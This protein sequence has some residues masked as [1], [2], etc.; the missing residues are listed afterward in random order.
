MKTDIDRL[1]GTSL[2]GRYRI[3][4]EIG[5]GGMGIVYRAHDQRL[6]RFVA[7]KMIRRDANDAT[8]RTRLWREAR[9]AATLSHPHLCRLY[10]IHE[11]AGELFLT[12]ELLDGESL[13]ARLKRGQIALAE[14]IEIGL[15]ILSALSEMHQRHLAHRDL[16]P[17]NVFLTSNGV[18]LL[19]FGLTRRIPTELTATETNLTMAGA[20]VGTPAYMAPEQVFGQP[21]DGRSDLFAL[22][23]VLFEML[24]AT[25][26]FR[27]DS[28][29]DVLHAITSEQPPMLTGS[30]CVVAVGRIVHRALA[31]NP[32]DRP[33]TAAEMADALRATL[34]VGDEH[35]TVTVRAI[36][37]IMV[38]PFRQLRPD[39]EL[40]FLPFGLAD[41]ITTA[42]AGL[43]SVIV[44]STLTAA[45]FATHE[46]SWQTIAADANVDVVLAGTLLRV[47]NELRVTAQL[48]ETPSGRVVWS[49]T[50][51]VS[52]H[53]LFRLQDDLA[54]AMIDAL[55]LPLTARE[56]RLLNH[57]APTSA[58]AYELYLRANP[59]AE[60]G[61]WTV[62]R[63]LYVE[64]LQ[65]DH[66]FAPGWARLG[67]VYRLLGKFGGHEGEL[68]QRRAEEAFGRAL[69]INP[70]L[71][72][73]HNQ[74]ARLEIDLGRA[75]DA[76]ARLLGRLRVRR[77]DPE[78]FA[79]L[80]QAC[81][82]CGLL[83]ASVAA[84]EA[85]R[86]LDPRM[87]T[88]VAHSYVML[89]RYHDALH[90]SGDPLTRALVLMMLGRKD[91]SIAVLR[92]VERMDAVTIR[93]WA[94]ASRLLVEGHRDEGLR[95]ARTVLPP[96]YKDPESRYYLAR[97][98]AQFGDR[99]SAV[100]LIREAVEG[101][102]F[103]VEALTTDPW[104]ESV[105]NDSS[106][107]RTVV[108]AARRHAAA[109]AVFGN[110][111]GSTLL[112][113]TLPVSHN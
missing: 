56:Q 17:S 1:R 12:M 46:P 76:M 32:D 64:C 107:Q 43:D 99:E 41:A 22:G 50:T 54:S 68:D 16:K 15:A 36:S 18:K 13:S 27:G 80:V 105:R 62:A 53:D 42:L 87:A 33:A 66:R 108:D 75:T 112:G 6:N 47:N 93:T 25:P 51:Q 96:S 84:H 100:G 79:A 72:I 85:A 71:S 83:D 106:F 63:D 74:Y 10:D 8:A 52:V 39:P 37:R 86:R 3:L 111:D 5:Q 58:K 90:A 23:C 95:L 65:E 31:K 40:E 57:D 61:A 78:I 34:R 89:G 28:I 94:T 103:C 44:R 91:D 110:A 24:T 48:V 26:A 7:L 19:D 20:I 14:A 55:A 67:R 92:E 101:G 35:E 104:L 60:Q 113:V 69:S 9:T 70:D 102:F 88:S 73:A 11:E 29:I 59:M 2:A 21:V 81:R 38:M 4:A 77:T 109:R 45:Q 30:S 98:L 97:Q 49:R 82:Y